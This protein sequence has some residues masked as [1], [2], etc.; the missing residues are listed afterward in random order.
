[1]YIKNEDFESKSKN[2]MINI[3]NNDNKLKKINLYKLVNSLDKYNK[4]KNKIFYYKNFKCSISFG[5]GDKLGW[6]CGYII[7]FN[8]D[9]DK[10]LEGDKLNNNILVHSK[11]KNIYKPMPHKEFTDFYAFD[12]GDY[13]SIEILRSKNNNYNI[14]GIK[15][16]NNKINTFKTYKFVKIELQKII[17]SMI[18]IS[19][20]KI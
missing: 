14:N 15:S 7:N 13:N 18:E 12:C 16:I 5:R 9:V 17:D 20:K 4:K 3:D 6:F 1:M 10:Y 19:N 8:K 2:I 11:M